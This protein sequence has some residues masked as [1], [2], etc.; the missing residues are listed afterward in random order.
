MKDLPPGWAWTT[1][2][3]IAEIGP[4]T[5]RAEIDPSTQVSFVPMAAV[6]AGTGVLNAFA[7]REWQQVSKG[8]VPFAEGDI[9]FARIT[10]CMENGKVAIAR[11]LTNGIGAGSTEFHVVRARQSIE[12]V[13]LLHYLLQLRIRQDARAVM[14][15]AAGQLRVPA[16]FLKALATSRRKIQFSAGSPS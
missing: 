6:E 2:G 4:V 8:Y 10:P 5:K 13:F 11:D 14:Q 12:P 15:G 3:E 1:L 9:L 16:T 7:T